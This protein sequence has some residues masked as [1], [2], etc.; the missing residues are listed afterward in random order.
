MVDEKIFTEC[1]LLIFVKKRELWSGFFG[2][3]L[4]QLTRLICSKSPIRSFY[5][6]NNSVIIFNSR[7]MSFG[8]HRVF[9]KKVYED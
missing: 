4:E 6:V 2:S 9:A 7:K 8:T 1:C 3:F 5:D